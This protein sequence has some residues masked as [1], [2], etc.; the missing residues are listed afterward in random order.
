MEI[1]ICI[2]ILAGGLF[3]GY[4]MGVVF[5][6]RENTTLHKLHELHEKYTSYWGT[7]AAGSNQLYD[8]INKQQTQNTTNTV[9]TIVQLL[10]SLQ[11]N[12][13]STLSQ[14][15]QKKV[16]RIIQEAQS[17]YPMNELRD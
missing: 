16:E 12:Q 3:L 13:S 14:E 1:F 15:D 11:Q 6:K 4:K 9:H 17:I 2:L 8:S 7:L 10:Q 5:I